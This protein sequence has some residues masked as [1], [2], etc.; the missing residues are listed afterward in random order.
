MF[1]LYGEYLLA[2][3]MSHYLAKQIEPLLTRTITWLGL[4][5]DISSLNKNIIVAVLT[6]LFI[7]IYVK[8]QKKRNRK[9]NRNFS[10]FDNK[11]SIKLISVLYSS[12]DVSKISIN[13]IMLNCSL[14]KPLKISGVTD[15]DKSDYK[16]KITHSNE[17]KNKMAILIIDDTYHVNEALIE[18]FT[19]NFVIKITNEAIGKRKDSDELEKL[20]ITLNDVLLSNGIKK[21]DVYSTL[22]I[23][24][25]KR[26]Y[27]G[28]CK[29]RSIQ[30]AE[31]K[32]RFNQCNEKLITYK[33]WLIFN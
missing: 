32:F 18:D 22:S 12:I 26:F 15:I 23:P 30:E 10:S 21:V 20:L 14:N 8:L 9:F 4:T 25:A 13:T 5:L 1:R 17:V 31:I 28:V 19:K 16:Y 7:C 6:I 24:N 3:L 2:I 33:K 11:F 27:N 29:V